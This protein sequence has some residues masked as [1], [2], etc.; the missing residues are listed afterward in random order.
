M[1][2]HTDPNLPS[3]PSLDRGSAL[4]AADSFAQNNVRPEII[5]DTSGLPLPV[6]T[7]EMSTAISD[8]NN[9]SSIVEKIRQSE[10][11]MATRQLQMIEDTSVGPQPL[12]LIGLVDLKNDDILQEIGTPAPL[13]PSSFEEHA[14]GK[15]KKASMPS[16]DGVDSIIVPT[17]EE[18][19]DDNQSFSNRVHTNI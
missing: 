18:I 12:P 5:D 19:E 14:A 3:S 7:A 15:K 11:S 10:D 4:T 9:V 2:G 17:R 1:E 16:S 8:S 6:G 13:H